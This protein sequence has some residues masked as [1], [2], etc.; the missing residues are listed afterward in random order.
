[1]FDVSEQFALV[2]Y[3]CCSPYTGYFFVSVRKAYSRSGFAPVD[4]NFINPIGENDEVMVVD[5]PVPSRKRKADETEQSEPAEEQQDL[6]SVKR[7][8]V[9]NAAEDGGEDIIVL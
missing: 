6:K 4:V 2:L 9:S 1:M 5:E 3:F 8:K 7:A